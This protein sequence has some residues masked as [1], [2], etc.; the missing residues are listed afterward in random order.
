MSKPVLCLDFDGVLHRYDS[1][2]RGARIIPDGPVDGAVAFLAAASEH[3]TIA[4]LSSRSHQEGGI[5]AMKVWVGLGCREMSGAVPAWFDAITWPTEKPSAM[6]TI[7]DRA[8][9]FTGTWPD[10]KDLLAFKPWNK[11]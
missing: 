11:Q 9:T 7:D 8:I 5:A 4:I 10:P 6:V 1:G 3:F 2:W